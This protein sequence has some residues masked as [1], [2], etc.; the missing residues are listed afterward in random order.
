M[1]GAIVGQV[2]RQKKRLEEP[3]S[4][5]QVP[6]GRT[7]VG[8]GLQAVIFHAQG[9]TDLERSLPHRQIFLQQGG[10]T[11]RRRGHRQ[12]ANWTDAVH[13]PCKCE[14]LLKFK[15]R[16]LQLGPTSEW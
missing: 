16:T 9:S 6:L 7:G 15:K 14:S 2:L 11:W 5:R 12:I 4:V 3:G 13:K 8:H 1:E 10:F